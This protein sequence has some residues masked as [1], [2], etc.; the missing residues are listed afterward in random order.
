MNIIIVSKD[1]YFIS[2][3]ISLIEEVWQPHGS[4]N[5]VFLVSEEN[6][7]LLEPDII[8]TDVCGSTA[9]R[10]RFLPASLR[11]DAEA[12]RY[13]SLFLANQCKFETS[14]CQKHLLHLKKNE[15]LSKIKRLF[16]RKNADG[17]CQKNSSSPYYR[18]AEDISLSK[19]QDMVVK[20]IRQGLSLTDISGVTGLSIKTIST[21]KRAIMRKL[22]MKNNSDFYRFA[23][24]GIKPH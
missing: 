22:G 4:G 1:S 18:P 16:N 9:R 19:Q 2:G 10:Q 17:S 6:R 20:Y 23:L 15:S 12:E 21:H 8:I 14:V 13:V 3:A 24:K 11:K 5:P 7:A